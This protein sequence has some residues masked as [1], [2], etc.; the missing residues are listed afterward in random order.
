[1]KL[2]LN[3]EQ[4]A[5]SLINALAQDEN[6]I[7]PTIERVLYEVPSYSGVAHKDLVASLARNLSLAV[8]A[9]RTREVPRPDEIW[10]AEKATLERLGANVPI[11]DIMSGFRISI[12]TI[13]GRLVE[14]SAEHPVASEDL[15][16]M[17]RLLWKLSD[18]FSARA[19]AA[20]RKYGMRLAVA[21]QRRTDE[22]LLSLLVGK[23]TAAAFERGLAS[24]QIE[25]EREYHPFC[26][27]AR[28]P[29][30][31]DDAHHLLDKQCESTGGVM[32]APYASRMVGILPYVPTPIAGC[33]IAVGPPSLPDALATSYQIANDVL[34]AALVHFDEGL[35][36]VDSLGWR[37]GVPKAPELTAMVRGRYVARLKGTGA[38]GAEVIAAVRA[39][40]ENERNIPRTAEALHIHVNTLRYRLSRF[41]EITGRSLSDTDTLIELSWALYSEREAV[42]NA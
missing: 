42:K 23:L 37:I 17:T 27:V 20:Y 3:D 5:A 26:A 1:M 15:V 41:E 21:E 9:L 36:T 29:G 13:Q 25:R 7:A 33:L 22:W 4:R 28:R 30:S 40:L 18:A 24:Y 16:T 34:D 11:E 35:H 10:Q 38:F 2:G 8:Q 19:A 6:T 14:L 12:A 32:A 39:L 31:V